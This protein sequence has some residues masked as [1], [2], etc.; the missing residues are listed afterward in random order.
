MSVELHLFSI[1]KNFI[2][3]IKIHVF[4]I[5]K[6]LLFLIVNIPG[7]QIIRILSFIHYYKTILLYLS[8][9]IQ[10]KSMK[11]TFYDLDKVLFLYF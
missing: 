8:F 11:Y 6:L 10:I 7:N 1:N 5:E 3:N 2:V 9:K 4:T